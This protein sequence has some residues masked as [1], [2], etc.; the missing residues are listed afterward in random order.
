MEEESR[1]KFVILETT[2]RCNLRCTHCAVSE[3]NNLGSYTYEDLPIEGFRA[4][5]PVLREH[6]PEVQLS[7]HGETLLHPHF[8]EMLQATLDAGCAVRLQTN[9]TILTQRVIDMLVGAG[10]ALVVV[11]IDAVTPSIFEGIRRR[12]KLHK[13][14][15]NLE[16]LVRTK[17][18]RGRERPDLAIE[19]VAM[20]QNIHELPQVMALAGRLG[21][22]EFS[23]TELKEYPLTVGQSLAG[24]RVMIEWAARAREEAQKWGY[25]LHL[26]PIP[27]QEIVG[28]EELTIDRASPESYR[29][30]KKTCREPWERAFVQY[31]GDVWPCCWINEPYGVL[32]EQSFAEVWS[33]ERYRALRAALASDTPPETCVRCPVYGWEPIEPE[34]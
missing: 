32:T 7:G 9:A 22:I 12:A 24:D 4:I 14:L 25:T 2:R 31:N 29:G 33:G 13:V 19:F 17:R 20:R 16:Q 5:L 26:P 3:E 15:A 30:L 18:E 10:A 23:V 1:L 21:A 8:E 34:G 11:S 27:G 6:R 28:V